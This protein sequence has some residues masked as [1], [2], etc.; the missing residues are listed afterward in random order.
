MYA[1]LLHHPERERFDTSALRVCFSGG[2][3]L[4][5]ELLRAFEDAFGCMIMEGYGLS[6]TLACRLLQPSGSDAEARVDR[7]AD[8]GCRDEA[9]RR[10]AA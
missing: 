1:A 2:A 10:R 9:R 3:A 7:D 6:E 4:P 5:V 8:R